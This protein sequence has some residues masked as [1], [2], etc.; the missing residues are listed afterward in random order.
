MNITNILAI[1]VCLFFGYLTFFSVSD[2]PPGF[3]F[4]TISFYIFIVTL[5]YFHIFIQKERTD[6][7]K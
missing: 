4:F 2:A 7:N 3:Q 5:A 6:K 1:L